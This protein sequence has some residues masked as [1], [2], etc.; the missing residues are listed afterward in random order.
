MK[1]ILDYI[2]DHI[3][4]KP[5]ITELAKSLNYSAVQFTRKFIKATGYT[6]A[7]YITKRKLHFA[8][9]DLITTNDQ[10]IKIAMRYNFESHDSFSRAFKRFYGI[11]PETFRRKGQHVPEFPRPFD[12]VKPNEPYDRVE[13]V[14][15]PEIK[16]IGIERKFRAPEQAW[17]VFGRM[18]DDVFRNAPNRVYP[19]SH[20]ITHILS[21]IQPDGNFTIF[22]GIEV[23][24]FDGAPKNADCYTLPEQEHAMLWLND[25]DGIEYRSSTDF[26]YMKWLGKSISGFQSGQTELYPIA[27][28]EYFMPEELRDKADPRTDA[29]YVPILPVVP[30][31]EMLKPRRVYS[32]TVE[33]EHEINP[34]DRCLKENAVRKMLD[35]IAND[36]GICDNSSEIIIVTE[37]NICEIMYVTDKI[38][39]YE[40]LSEK[41][42]K[43]GECLKVETCNRCPHIAQAIFMD[44]LVQSKY[45]Y[46]VMFESYKIT[47]NKLLTLTPMDLYA[48]M[49]V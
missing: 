31:K 32:F 33:N 23:T 1:Q 46:S 22:S 16:L 19:N 28:V 34:Y 17:E 27:T 35:I 39:N 42:L 20:G 14:T 18:Y 4:E 45:N 49:E 48:C 2:E 47:E 36:C 26:L 15:L 6:P 10:I 9:Y 30:V 44:F 13:I 43:G 12:D 8:A 5:D 3:T 21:I 24:G 7:R 40:E 37:K 38:I 25:D 41:Q 29:V 11:S